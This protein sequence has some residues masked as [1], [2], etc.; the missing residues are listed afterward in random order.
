MVD[1]QDAATALFPER[2][3]DRLRAARLAA[4]MD[5]SDVA[6]KTRVPLRHLQAIEAGDYAALPGSTYCIGFVKAFARAIGVDDQGATDDLRAELR[7]LNLDQRAERIEYQV[8]DAT[9]LPSKTLAWVTAAI[10]L[11]FV[12]AFVLWRATLVSD[13]D[14]VTEIEATTSN[15][16]SVEAVGA[17]DLGPTV[18][19]S[20][21]TPPAPDTTTGQVVLTATSPVWMRIYDDADKVL[22]EKEMVAGER[23]IVP[24]DANNPQIRTGRADLI[25]VSVDGKPVAALGPAERTIKDVGVSAAAL[26]ARTPIAEGSTSNAP[27]PVGAVPVR[28]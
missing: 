8:A 19:S 24:A 21:E 12:V 15:E 1:N 13:P 4:G 17:D 2:V 16:A 9:R 26:A 28:P 11:L 7:A 22:F 3:G 20:L 10:G 25:A 23:F 6:T 5:L 27:T 18:P 14:P